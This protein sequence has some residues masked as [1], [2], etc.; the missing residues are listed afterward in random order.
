MDYNKVGKEITHEKVNDNESATSRMYAT[1]AVNVRSIQSPTAEIL[2][3]LATGEAIEVVEN[4]GE[5]CRVIYNGGEGCIM[6]EYLSEDE[7]E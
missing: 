1:C 4:Q 3:V 2:G 5:W 7:A 6:S